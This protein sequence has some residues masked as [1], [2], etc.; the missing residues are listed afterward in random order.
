VGKKKTISRE[1]QPNRPPKPHYTL[2]A[3][4]YYRQVIAPLVKAYQQAMGAKNY[5]E[6]EKIFNQIREEKK[7][8]RLLLHRK[9]MVRIK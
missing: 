7:H 6:A 5:E 9:E 2:K 1:K 8:H 3:N 4:L